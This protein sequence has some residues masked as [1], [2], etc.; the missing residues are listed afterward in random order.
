M[1]LIY[2]MLDRSLML[3]TESEPVRMALKG[4]RHTVKCL[5]FH[6]LQCLA[7]TYCPD[8]CNAVY[9]AHSLDICIR[10]AFI[11]HILV[12]LAYHR[13]VSDRK[14]SCCKIFDIKV[15]VKTRDD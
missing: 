2:F 1:R 10:Y 13:A 8:I 7:H 5:S 12:I 6:K 15:F 4:L 11:I 14:V 3:F 9:P